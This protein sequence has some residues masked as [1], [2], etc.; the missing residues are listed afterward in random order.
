MDTPPVLVPQK[1]PADPQFSLK[2]LFGILVGILVVATV[3]LAGW[4]I[5]K[6]QGAYAYTIP[7]VPALTIYYGEVL[8]SNIYV[9]EKAAAL[10]SVL[11]YW[12]DAVK[13]NDAALEQELAPALSA[14]DI[15][16]DELKNI[17]GKRGYT[18]E[19]ITVQD[20]R[21]LKNFLTPKN[22]VPLI[23]VQAVSA[24]DS[25]LTQA[26]LVIGIDTIKDLV[27]TH[28]YLRGQTYPISFS[29]YQQLWNASASSTR[30]QYI[31]IFPSDRNR[32]LDRIAKNS[33]APAYLPRTAP[34][35]ALSPVLPAYL[36]VMRRTNTKNINVKN[37]IELDNLKEV[38]GN[39][40]F[41][42]FHPAIQSRLYAEKGR[43]ETRLG[44]YTE[45]LADIST[46]ITLDKGL[47]VPV[48]GWGMV[49]SKQ[50]PAPFFS[51]SVY[52]KTTG[53]SKKAAAALKQATAIASTSA[54]TAEMSGR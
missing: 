40:A 12:G 5:Y 28:D 53:D 47:D 52:Y 25:N 27:I 3:G 36:K 24:A 19:M 39:P 32:I 38:I 16:I 18:V 31:A 4:K 9:P 11:Q 37:T 50:I 54:A 17:L 48:A 46:A 15:N 22:P 20:P 10:V 42:Y 26:R 33:T 29:D 13:L 23:S 43:V 1:A 21:D 8:N 6:M 41:S 30:Y 51:L 34:M 14:A 45:A 2:F 35:D 7:G 49:Y 44:Q